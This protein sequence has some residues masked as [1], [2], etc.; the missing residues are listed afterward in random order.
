MSKTVGEIF[1]M[2]KTETEKKQTMIQHL[3]R[4]VIYSARNQICR[5]SKIMVQ[6]KKRANDP[7]G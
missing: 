4:S 5:M 3:R 7:G 1:V 2:P 6:A